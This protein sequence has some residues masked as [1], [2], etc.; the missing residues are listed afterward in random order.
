MKSMGDI[1]SW[2]KDRYTSKFAMNITSMEGQGGVFSV[3][4]IHICDKWDLV[5]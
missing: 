5:C 4:R 1:H 2:K 3:C